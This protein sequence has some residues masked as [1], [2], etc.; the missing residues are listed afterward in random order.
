VNG[1]GCLIRCLPV[2]SL[3]RSGERRRGDL[4]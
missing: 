2:R 1:T 4:P 3:K